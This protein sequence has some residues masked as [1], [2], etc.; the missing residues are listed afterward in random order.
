MKF[1][2]LEQLTFLA[3]IPELNQKFKVTIRKH[4]L[5]VPEPAIV[6]IGFILFKNRIYWC[7]MD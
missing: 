1:K 6:S 7:A 3:D 5:F 4:H 2:L